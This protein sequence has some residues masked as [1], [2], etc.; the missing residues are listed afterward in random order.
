MNESIAGVK[1]EALARS[2][3]TGSPVVLSSVAA[4]ELADR[5]KQAAAV[6]EKAGSY[7][8]ADDLASWSD[9]L[10]AMAADKSDT[11]KCTEMWFG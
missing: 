3:A 6:C 4:Q 5:L 9:R 11:Q 7:D 8:L 1:Q 10:C 2:V